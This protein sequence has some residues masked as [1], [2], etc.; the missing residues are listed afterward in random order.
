MPLQ[1]NF[2]EQI[3]D[4]VNSLTAADKMNINEVI[5]QEA[6]AV[7]DFARNHTVITGV[8]NGSY[9]PIIMAGDDFGSMPAGD[10]KSCALNEC[11]LDTEYSTKKW[12]LGEYNCRIPICMRSF[13]E[14]FLLF[15]NMYRQRLE[16]PLNEP[17]AQAFLT[18][19]TDRVESRLKGTQWRV[20]YLGDTSSS[21]TLI[22]NNEGYFTLAEAGDGI[23]IN[24]TQEEPTPEE[25]YEYFKEAYEASSGE[26]WADA[27]D[28]VWK[29]THKMASKFVAFLNTRA[30]L[31][32]YNCDCVNPDAIVAGRRF[33]V[34][35]LR[36][37]GIPVEAHREID[38]SMKAV[39]QDNT[40][41]AL[42]IRKSNLLASTNS[43]DKMATF[44]MFY[45]RKDMKIYIDTMVYLG[46]GIPLD[47]YV[48]LS[49][50]VETTPEP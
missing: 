14:D 22:N 48:Y 1:G 50:D 31:S 7:S 36:I 38:G 33:T 27:P 41:R 6:F 17:D 2:N 29:M 32:Q 16:N 45:D 46:A 15:W 24:I 43:I 37:F 20:G 13:D 18:F 28:L 4:V 5:F 35:G 34:E 47:E 30:D 21:N 42:L 8:R 40:F 39:G 9:M 49:N 44:D 3:V 25:M 26:I 23:K 10:E 12:V 11:D 19:I